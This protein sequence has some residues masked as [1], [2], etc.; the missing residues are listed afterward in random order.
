MGNSSDTDPVSAG[1]EPATQEAATLRAGREK[2]TGMADPTEK[3]QGLE[4]SF[5]VL[6][7][8]AAAPRRVSDVMRLMDLPWATAHRTV[9]KLEK[10]QFLML[11]R[12]TSRY[13][14]GPRLW[15]LGSSYLAN[16]RTLKSAISYLASEAGIRGVDIQIVERI[17]N[18]SVVI[19]AEKRQTQEIS[20][21]QYGYHIPL[22]AGS[23]GLVLLA[24][25]SPDFVDAYLAQPLE[26]LTPQ[27][28]TD[29]A[30][31]RTRLAAIR[32]AGLARTEADVQLFTGSIAAPV[33]NAA[34]AI[35]G[36]VCFVYLRKQA[37]D[38][39]AMAQLTED[40]LRMTHAIST[41]L[42]H[43]QGQG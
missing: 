4:R 34:G 29:P 18:F 33:F 1:A 37:E 14:I 19:H 10:A 21:A 26:A 41:D 24:W 6:D 30:A 43:H 17:G 32:G 25:E 12:E 8:I 39:G 11:N 31:V 3:K 15:H 22:H 36:C 5:A 40:L 9:K 13:E 2:P 27:T 42:G 16:N 23:K 35:A 28:E 38:A 7:L 20:K